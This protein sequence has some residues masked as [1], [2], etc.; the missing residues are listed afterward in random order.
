MKVKVT[1][2]SVAV[3]YLIAVI[4]S[5]RRTQALPLYQDTNLEPQAGEP[6]FFFE[7][8]HSSFNSSESTCV[9][10]VMMYCFFVLIAK[11]ISDKCR[12]R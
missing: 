2:F 8:L 7:C 1:M 11:F 12:L 5:P 6:G 9:P 4:C 10:L 3:F